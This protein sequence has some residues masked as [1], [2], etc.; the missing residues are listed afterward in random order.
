MTDVISSLHFSGRSQIPQPSI[1]SFFVMDNHSYYYNNGQLVNPSSTLNQYGG[2]PQLINSLNQAEITQKNKPEIPVNIKGP[3]VL[4]I[5]QV[6]MNNTIKSSRVCKP[7]P[8]I[9]ANSHLPNCLI[10]GDSIALR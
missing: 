7:G 8:P 10:I 4:N 6:D 2:G 9:S 1:H 5:T 3:S